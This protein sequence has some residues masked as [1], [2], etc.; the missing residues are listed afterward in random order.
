MPN[1]I[2]LTL[3]LTHTI[4]GTFHPIPKRGQQIPTTK[5]LSPQIDGKAAHPTFRRLPWRTWFLVVGR[6]MAETWFGTRCQCTKRIRNQLW[7]DSGWRT[8][9]QM[10]G[11]AAAIKNRAERSR[12]RITAPANFFTN[13][14]NVTFLIC[15]ANLPSTN[16]SQT[17]VYKLRRKV[18]FSR[19]FHSEKS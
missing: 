18:D 14:P 8:K 12:V 10:L 6:R 16:A 1:L 11:T 7:K 9:K 3:T 19:R 13:W 15:R 5:M 2:Q 4:G 17:R